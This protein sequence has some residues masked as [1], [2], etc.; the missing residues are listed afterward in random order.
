[1]HLAHCGFPVIG[2]DRYAEGPA[3]RMMLHCQHVAFRAG[4]GRRVATTAPVDAPF[5]EPCAR[6]GVVMEQGI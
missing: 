1:M 6:A 2:D 4:D 3:A 5:R